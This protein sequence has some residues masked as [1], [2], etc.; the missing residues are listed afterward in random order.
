MVAP[1]PGEEGQPPGRRV[2]LDLPGLAVGADVEDGVGG[3][4]LLNAH[5]AVA[6]VEFIQRHLCPNPQRPVD[7]DEVIIELAVDQRRGDEG[8]FDVEFVGPEFAGAGG[9]PQKDIAAPRLVAKARPPAEIGV[10]GPCRGGVP[11]TLAEK[12]VGNSRDGI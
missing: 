4:R 5:I 3:A 7:A 2:V 12:G 9:T 8:T 11:G 10:A 1:P 6:H